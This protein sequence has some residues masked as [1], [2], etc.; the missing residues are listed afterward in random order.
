[1][2]G[3]PPPGT[4]PGPALKVST[5]SRVAKA[6]MATRPFQIS[7]Q[8]MSNSQERMWRLCRGCAR[9]SETQLTLH[10]LPRGLL[11]LMLL[12]CKGQGYGGR[13]TAQRRKLVSQ[14]REHDTRA[15]T[16]KQAGKLTLWV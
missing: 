16:V 1:M 2:E 10:I 14:A 15:K 4:S 11:I 13:R 5:T 6:T 9:E 3:G 12:V 8:H 7:L